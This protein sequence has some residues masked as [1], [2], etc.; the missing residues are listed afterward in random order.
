METTGR[1]YLVYSDKG[2]AFS[3]WCIADMHLLNVGVA[4]GRLR[5]DIQAIADDPFSF[6]FGAGDYCDFIGVGD[7][8]W[9]PEAMALYVKVQDLGRL[10]QMGRD[11]AAERLSPIADSCLGIGVGNHELSYMKHNE[12]MDLVKNMAAMLDTWYLG[13]SSFTDLVFIYCPR[14]KGCPKLVAEDDAPKGEDRFRVRVMIHHGHG[15][16][17]T[18]GG[19]INKLMGFMRNFDADITFIGHLHDQLLKSRV[20]LRADSRCE[21]LVDIPQIGM[22]TGTYLRSYAPG[23]IGYGELKAYEPA[24]LGAV[25]VQVRPYERELTGRVSIQGRRAMAGEEGL[26]YDRLQE[27]LKG[28]EDGQED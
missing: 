2:A 15:Y 10:G 28:E 13:Y 21:E 26:D 9:D 7:N 19:K 4:E 22:M 23:N 24:P 8:R 1:R 12:Q 11:L 3:L 5:E 14:C 27:L 17:R 16:A 18:Q 25:S 6:W 20:R